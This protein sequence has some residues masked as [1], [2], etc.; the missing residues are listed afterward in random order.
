MTQ[1]LT[2]ERELQ[3]RQ[4]LSGVSVYAADCEDADDY[5]YHVPELLAEIDALRTENASLTRIVGSQLY[6]LKKLRAALERQGFTPEYINEIEKA[7]KFVSYADA[8]LERAEKAT[9]S[10]ISAEHVN[11]AEVAVPELARRLKRAIKE[12]RNPQGLDKD[13]IDIFNRVADELEGIPGNTTPSASDGP[14]EEIKIKLTESDKDLA[15][16]KVVCSF[17][18]AAII[19][20]GFSLGA[21]S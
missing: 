10:I 9:C 5:R 2:P 4:A 8:C 12:L 18:A 14:L 3:I 19:L 11:L 13:V 16:M 15:E 6:E 21:S 20:I 1:R 7:E 17:V